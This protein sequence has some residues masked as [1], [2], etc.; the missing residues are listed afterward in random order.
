MKGRQR[1]IHRKRQRQGERDKL[2]QRKRDTQRQKQKGQETQ[3][4]PTQW[5]RLW[6]LWV[7]TL[8]P[9]EAWFIS[10]IFHLRKQRPLRASPVSKPPAAAELGQGLDLCEG[11]HLPSPQRQRAQDHSVPQFT[12]LQNEEAR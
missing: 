10:Y 1:D 4:Y 3:A 5:D 8:P 2:R 6:G 12:Q 11:A 9:W 7:P